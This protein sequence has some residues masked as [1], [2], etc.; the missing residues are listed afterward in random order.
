MDLPEPGT[1]PGSPASQAD[2]SLT[3]LSGKADNALKHHLLKTFTVQQ[4]NN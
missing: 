4:L 2:S 1:E 3:E